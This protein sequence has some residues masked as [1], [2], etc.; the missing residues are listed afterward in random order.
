MQ[1]IRNMADGPTPK[2]TV[3]DDFLI[4]ALVAGLGVAAVTGPMGCLLVWR[5]MAFFG[6][7]L[8][9]AALLGIAVGLLFDINVMLGVA[10]TSLVLVLVLTA[11]GRQRAVPS[12]AVLAILS[13][14]GLATGYIAISLLEGVRVDL[15]G[16]LFGDILAVDGQD[17]WLILG[18]GAV[19]LGVIAALWKTAI[20]VAVDPD[21]ARA[22]GVPVQAVNLAVVLVAA[23]AVAVAVKVVG[24]LM[25]AAMLIMPPAIARR[26]ARTPEQMVVLAAG[27][28]MVA[29]A[30]G[31]GASLLWDLPAGPAIVAAAAV[32]IAAAWL[33][34]TRRAAPG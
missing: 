28:G 10:A 24:I 7:T 9:H 8:A 15:L 22:D 31:L 12:D 19:V 23:L 16:Y 34:P 32:M 3:M 26:F 11:A 5:R 4:R 33:V 17:L 14:G 6:D 21:L 2:T 25:I 1:T 13:H 18:G 20:A 29:V 27:A 30:L